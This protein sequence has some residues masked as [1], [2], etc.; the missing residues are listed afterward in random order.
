MIHENFVLVSFL[1]LSLIL[2]SIAFSLKHFFRSAKADKRPAERWKIRFWRR[3]VTFFILVLIISRLILLLTGPAELSG[4]S[5]IS[6]RYLDFFIGTM[7]FVILWFITVYFAIIEKY[8]KPE[9]IPQFE[10]KIILAIIILALVDM[11]VSGYLFASGYINLFEPVPDLIGSFRFNGIEQSVP[12]L[13]LIAVSFIL[14]VV[15]YFL[16]T[17]KRTLSFLNQYLL[18]CLVLLTATTIFLFSGTADVMGWQESLRLKTELLSWR[19][20][21]PGQIMALFFGI[22]FFAWLT[23]IIILFIKR[24]FVD[25]SRIRMIILPLIRFGVIALTGYCF[26]VVFPFLFNHLSH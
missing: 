15:F 17:V 2:V 7:I 4:Y 20:G 8:L 9:L 13:V 23:T 6:G 3:S 25:P 26:L 16:F 19:Y 22:S 21:F 5:Q 14:T 12:V 24:Y 1:A 10:R 11:L 18:S